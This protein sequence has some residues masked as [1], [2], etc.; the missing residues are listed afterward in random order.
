MIIIIDHTKIN[1]IT[2]YLFICTINC[3]NF[4]FIK[5]EID[6]YWLDQVKDK[7]DENVKKI[8]VGNKVDISEVLIFN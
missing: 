8:L 2:I 7:C 4:N 5:L 1:N 6:D 3:F